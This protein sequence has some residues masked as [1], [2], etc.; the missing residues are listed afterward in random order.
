MKVL[1]TAV[2]GLG[3]VGWR[4]H[5]PQILK[6]KDMLSLAAVVDV[7]QERLEEAKEIY[8]VSG[9]TDV[10]EMVHAEKPDLVVIASPTHLHHEHACTAMKL[11]THVFLDKPMAEDHET[12]CRIAKCAEE[13]G[14]KLMVFQP[15]RAT[16][17][18]NQLMHIIHSGKIGRLIS[19]HVSRSSYVRRSDWQAFQ[20]Y[21]GGMLNN[22]GAHYI[23]A[24][25]YMAQDKVRRLYCSK[26]IV[27]SAGDADD[28]V[29]I[30]F[31]TERGITLDIDIN[32]AAALSGPNWVVYGQ[33]G[34]IISETSPEGKAQFRLRWFDPEA[35][36]Q[37]TA[38]EELAAANRSYNNDVSLPWV[39]KVIPE[40]SAYAV[41]FYEKVYEYIAEDKAPYVPITD[42]LYVMELIKRCHANAEQ[43]NS[44]TES[45]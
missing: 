18:V 29:K 9:Y 44:C 43:S 21:G 38:S 45:V 12:A 3:R 5:I 30:L 39:T 14:R 42:A 25:L 28:V 32:Q 11:G 23:D 1:K 7:S 36:P 15:H 40:D 41:D 35:I 13:T 16:A 26:D 34:A 37:I 6:H 19:I 4:Y 27:A 20:K 2:V 24:L 10:A 33:Y 17:T 31:Q 8:G 22:Y